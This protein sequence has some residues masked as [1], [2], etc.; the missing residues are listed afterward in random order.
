LA[1][2]RDEG[3]G[4]AWVAADAPFVL[5]AEHFGGTWTFGVNWSGTSKAFGI[6][7][8]IDFDEDAARQA[9]EDWFN[10]L[11]V[12][13]PVQFELSE[14]VLLSIDPLTDAVSFAINNDSSIVTKAS[15]ATE[16][17][18]GYSRL[19]RSNG[20]GRLYLGAE[21]RFYLMRLSRLTVRFGDITD[22]EEL[23]DAIRDSNFSND[24]RVGIDIGALWV[25]ENYQFGAQLT[26]VNEPKFTFPDIDLDHYRDGRII[27]LIRGDQTYTMDRQLKFEASLFT[28]DRSWSTHLGFDADSATDP[29]GDDFQWMTWSAGFMTES[30]WLPG[31]RIGYRQNLAGTKMKY[32]SIGVTAFKIVNIDLASA[33]DTVNIDGTK[34]PQ[35]LM[36]SLGFQLTW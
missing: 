29:M 10:T 7:Q 28:K 17:N 2:I 31:V 32:A 33:L 5:G 19:A 6:V 24:N 23:F 25:G 35:G 22:S 18:V 15:Q 12:D 36:F 20:A 14:E 3:Y 4:K 16:L 27:D 30:W 1:L 21:A 26:N 9:L 34:L 11:P 13:R 8:P